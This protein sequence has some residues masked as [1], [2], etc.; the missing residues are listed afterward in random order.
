MFV[1]ESRRFEVDRLLVD[2]DVVGVGAGDRVRDDLV[3]DREAGC[4]TVERIADRSDD[5]CEFVADGDG[6]FRFV[7]AHHSAHRLGVGGIDADRR[8]LNDDLSRIRER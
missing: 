6:K 2:D 7:R 5:T 4:L 8:D 1:V 3:A